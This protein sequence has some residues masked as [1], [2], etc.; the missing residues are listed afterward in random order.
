MKRAGEDGRKEPVHWVCRK[1]DKKG[2]DGVMELGEGWRKDDEHESFARQM[3][4]HVRAR[5]S[6]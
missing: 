5:P 3:G 4:I 1:V 6:E 2:R